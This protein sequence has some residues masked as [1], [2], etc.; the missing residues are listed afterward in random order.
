[1]V[2]SRPEEASTFRV[3][4][5][6]GWR[7]WRRRLDEVLG[8]P[9]TQGTSNG[10]PIRGLRV[11]RTSEDR[12]PSTWRALIYLVLQLEPG[13]MD[14]WSVLSVHEGDVVARRRFANTREADAARLRF[15]ESAERMSSSEYEH[16]D[17]QALLD[18]S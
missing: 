12:R 7:P 17:W 9:A 13:H 3:T 18:A 16:A 2:D 6:R 10:V 14:E 15:V 11:L 1:M 4:D 5:R 8:V